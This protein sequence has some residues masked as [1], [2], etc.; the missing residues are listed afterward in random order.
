MEFGSKIFIIR[1]LVLAQKVGDPELFDSKPVY[2]EID[3]GFIIFFKSW[4]SDD[5]EDPKKIKI[6]NHKDLQVVCQDDQYTCT[7]KNYYNYYADIAKDPS[8]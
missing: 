5:G 8:Q 6:L 3:Q 2:L 1:G 7:L 4:V